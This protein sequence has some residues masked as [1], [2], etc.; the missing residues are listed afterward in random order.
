LADKLD[1]LE[2]CGR[3][4]EADAFGGEWIRVPGIYGG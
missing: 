3:R 4:P 1:A 2:N